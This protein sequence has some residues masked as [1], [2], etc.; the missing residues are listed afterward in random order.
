MTRGGESTLAVANRAFK[1][2]SSGGA[3]GF[4]IA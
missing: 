1:S 3:R 2:V 4:D